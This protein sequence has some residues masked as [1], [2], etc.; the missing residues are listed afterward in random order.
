MALPNETRETIGV[1]VARMAEAAMEECNNNRPQ[2]SALMQRWLTEEPELGAQ[3]DAHFR[4]EGCDRAVAGVDADTR[5]TLRAVAIRALPEERVT[6]NRT[7]PLAP[8][9]QPDISAALVQFQAR[10][11][12]DEDFMAWP[13]PGGMLLGN[14]TTADVQHA[15]RYYCGLERTHRINRRFFELVYEAM[16]GGSCVRKVLPNPMLKRLRKQAEEEV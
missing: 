16:H 6:R 2:A 15:A 4:A 1:T 14:A 7:T 11:D 13:L 5:R 9:P 3:A 8:R 12:A 10:Q